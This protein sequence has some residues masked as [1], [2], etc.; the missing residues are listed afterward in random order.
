MGA[1]SEV[2]MARRKRAEGLSLQ[3]VAIGA[4]VLVVLIVV[5][6]IFKGGINKIEPTL[7][8]VNECKDNLLDPT[9]GC[10]A[11]GQCKSGEEI[12]GLGCE[13]KGKGETPYCCVK[14]N[15]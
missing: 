9:D 4:I 5:L 1:E 6:A 10:L 7:G 15:A 8:K 11:A 14:Q 3:V 12:Y 2:K 13:K